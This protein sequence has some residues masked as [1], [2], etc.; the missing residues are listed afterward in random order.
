MSS[1]SPSGIIKKDLIAPTGSSASRI[2][3]LDDVSKNVRSGTWPGTT[4]YSFTSATIYPNIA[5]STGPSLAQVVAG[6]TGT[7]DAA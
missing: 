7:G 6:T 2:W 1:R 5:G 3:E 4:I